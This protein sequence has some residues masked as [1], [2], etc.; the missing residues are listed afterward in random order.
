MPTIVCY[1]L[2]VERKSES[3]IVKERKSEIAWEREI[4]EKV[5]VCERE[6]EI[7]RE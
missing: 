4:K 6:R 5:C 7:E 3:E 2:A 1:A